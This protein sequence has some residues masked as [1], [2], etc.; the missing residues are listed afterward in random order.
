MFEES[1]IYVLEG[2]R[3]S[4][5]NRRII[6]LGLDDAT[7]KSIAA[8]FSDS[9]EA[10]ILGNSDNPNDIIPYDPEYNITPDQPECMRIDGF[11]L[12][13]DMNHAIDHCATLANYQLRKNAIPSI[14]AFFVCEQ[15]CGTKRVAFQRFRSQQ[16]LSPAGFHIFFSPETLQQENSTK[17][18]RGR[19]HAGLTISP[20]VDCYI[21][22]RGLIL[23]SSFYA[24]QIFDLSNYVMEASKEE[25]SKFVA[26]SL[27][28]TDNRDAIINNMGMRERKKIASISKKRILEEHPISE[29]EGIAH[30]FN[31][32]LGI[33][34]D[35]RIILPSNR[36]K[37][38]EL[39]AFLDEDIYRGSFSDEVYLSN[40]K[41]KR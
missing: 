33:S 21:D 22:D 25:I 40:S 13:D 35:G 17:W 11:S 9:L 29:I 24:N 1:R 18:Y 12:P 38:N 27:F 20:I 10:Q 30:Q 32:P 39:L 31:F 2:D 16:Y 14:R 7:R 5:E 15:H 37:R 6:C 26:S 4:S 28:Y 3:A 19:G 8:M 34:A 23:K 36:K 41:R